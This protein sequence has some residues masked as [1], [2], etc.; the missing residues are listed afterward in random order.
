ME[1]FR[2]EELI[3]RHERWREQIIAL[4]KGFVNKEEYRPFGTIEQLLG[5]KTL[6]AVCQEQVAKRPWVNVTKP[7]STREGSASI[8]ARGS[9]KCRKIGRSQRSGEEYARCYFCRTYIHLRGSKP[10]VRLAI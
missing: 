7:T 6:A 3:E 9:R 2:W 4:R 5:K 1:Q 10:D 8:V